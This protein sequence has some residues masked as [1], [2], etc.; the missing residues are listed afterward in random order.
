MFVT[1]DQKQKKIIAL[2]SSDEI[3]LFFFQAIM[4]LVE[5]PFG[6]LPYLIQDEI[7]EILDPED[8]IA[9][10]RTNNS[11]YQRCKRLRKFPLKSLLIN[12][13]N[14]SPAFEVT[15]FDSE[16]SEKI[17]FEHLSKKISIIQKLFIKGV[18][19]NRCEF[20]FLIF[21]YFII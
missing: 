12:F 4:A 5:F 7:V 2:A 15:N 8:L 10:S 19:P 16:E 11:N 13:E 21:Y 1:K 6:H 14:E 3:Y 20:L 9:L 18:D 17:T